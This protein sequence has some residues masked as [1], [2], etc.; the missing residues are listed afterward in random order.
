MPVSAVEPDKGPRREAHE[1]PLR[2]HER[3]A[4]AQRIA[5]QLPQMRAREGYRLPRNLRRQA[6]GRDV[7]ELA[8]G[9]L[10]D[11]LLQ[12][13]LRRPGRQRPAQR[14]QPPADLQIACAPPAASGKRGHDTPRA[15][16]VAQDHPLARRRARRR[17]Q[18]RRLEELVLKEQPLRHPQPPLQ[19]ERA[20][21]DALPD[22]RLIDA[23]AALRRK[24]RAAARAGRRGDRGAGRL[25]A[26]PI[27][28]EDEAPLRHVQPLPGRLARQRQQ[29]LRHGLVVAVQ[30]VDIIALC[31]I[32]PRVARG[33]EA[34]V[35]RPADQPGLGMR[36][37][38]P[39][40]DRRG[41][42]RSAV[43]H[44]QQLAFLLREQGRARKARVQIRLHLIDRDHNA[45]QHPISSEFSP[46]A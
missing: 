40:R 5:R 31:R 45:E 42:V 29:R 2:R 4:G 38:K 27:V 10:P 23:R 7:L 19:Q 11:A 37:H 14:V 20:P 13:P 35:L 44:E 30:E 24:E 6:V 25:P 28:K 12:R 39:L 46:L 15:R 33:G 32:Q 41:A 21:V 22:H 18:R 26:R 36:L 43:V 1:Q 34:A 3:V 17:Q 8:Q 16:A 9:D